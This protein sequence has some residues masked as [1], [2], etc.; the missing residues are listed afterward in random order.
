MTDFEN[1]KPEDAP[2]LPQQVRWRVHLSWASLGAERLW[3]ILWPAGGIVGLF[4][5]LALAN[6]FA[7]L[8]E[9]LHLISL[10]GFIAAIIAAGAW[11]LRKTEVP[12]RSQ[13]VR[14]LE[15]SSGLQH[16]PLSTLEDRPAT[17]TDDDTGL[18]W[19][20]HRR[21][22]LN[23]LHRLKVAWPKLTLAATDPHALRVLIILILAALTVA[24]WS[25]VPARLSA[26]I[27]P[28][29]AQGN[30]PATFEA[31]VTPPPYTGE[32]P[33]HMTAAAPSTTQNDAVN[34]P[35]G[36]TLT[37]R[38]HGD[39]S[40]ILRV[41]SLGS[42]M[43][44]Q[45]RPEFLPAGGDARDAKLPIDSDMTV[46][47]SLNASQVALWRFKIV[48]DKA[49]EIAFKSPLAIT[50]AQSLRFNYMIKDDYGVAS[51]DAQIEL[52]HLPSPQ[53]RKAPAPLVFE[54]PL[55]PAPARLGDAAVFKDLTAHVWAGLPV[56]V[57]LVARDELGQIGKS[58]PI[59][60]IL[61][62]RR[63]TDPFARALIEQRRSLAR[64]SSSAPLV[65][66]ALDALS[67]APERFV[68]DRRTYLALRAA[69]FMVAR[70][71]GGQEIAD[72]QQ[73]LWDL[74]LRIED[75]DAPQAQAELRAIQ[76]Q[77]M[78]ALAKGAP[79]EEIERLL[80]QL[81][82]AIDRAV[83]SMAEKAQG[84]NSFA[85]GAAGQVVRPQDLQ[86]MLEAIQNLS[87]QGSRAAAQQMLS[88][89]QNM[90]ENMQAM[91]SGKM[92]P[93]QQSATDAL[94]KLGSMIAQQRSLMD[95]TFREQRENEDS[96]G[97]AGKPS[98][99]KKEQEKLSN[100]LT[101]VM[102]KAGKG[103]E[104]ASALRRAQDSMDQ[105]TEDLG[106]GKL[107]AAGESQQKAIDELRRGGEAAAKQLLQQMAG[108]GS[109]MPGQ[110]GQG[111]GENEDPFG[112]PQSSFGPSFGDSVKVP[113]KLNIQKARE[114]LEELQRR[115][116]ERGR[117]SNELDYIERLL[118]RF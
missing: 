95:K 114:I 107:G 91:G 75:G 52:N 103:D 17:G 27:S 37:V 112:R 12:T 116:A 111:A 16:R 77:L 65:A 43:P 32:A 89:L 11:S 24:N 42:S 110:G 100:D 19:H 3:P 79:D 66:K 53:Q 49:P 54:L 115:S 51:A 83:K 26:A 87:R 10:M 104:I 6:V 97:R 113:D 108:Q 106:N 62:E 99:L 1:S 85:Q 67:I 48:A 117:P 76:Q 56:T 39:A 69:Y 7:Y 101:P 90:L 15:Q 31:W 2:G 61:P 33:R 84:Q 81:R 38:T 94:E 93:E 47:L 28:G 105:A 8:P 55:P 88:Q 92:S 68:P 109:T 36:S 82:S 29:W 102:K 20:A 60:L 59:K 73:L 40:A 41:G 18:L 14:H 71:H 98:A 63:F 45:T 46:R 50:Q 57:T 13:A 4:F 72:A 34:L 86:A 23:H 35:R 25:D 96:P 70:A 30:A 64:D 58:V 9:W 78:E 80:A 5:I 118:R 21:W 22:V 44:P 74:A